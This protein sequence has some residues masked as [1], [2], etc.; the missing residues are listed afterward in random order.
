MTQI[1]N[2]NNISGGMNSTANNSNYVAV[3]SVNLG[4]SIAH[5]PAAQAQIEDT[6]NNPINLEWINKVIY[7]NLKLLTHKKCGRMKFYINR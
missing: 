5:H 7:L 1:I 2:Q 4:P 3:S 6:L